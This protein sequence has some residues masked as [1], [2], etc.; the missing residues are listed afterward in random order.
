MQAIIAIDVG[1]TGTKAALIDRGGRILASGYA[2]YDTRT[3][4][5]SVMEQDPRDWWAATCA[6][7][8]QMWSAAPPAE[9]AAVALS[10]QM[11]DLILLDEQEAL[12]PAILYADSRATA[13]A[14]QLVDLFGYAKLTRITGNEQGPSS[15]LAK[16]LWLRHHDSTRLDQARA[17]LLGAHDYVEWRLCGSRAA[18]FTTASTTGLLDLRAN[19]WAESLIEELGLDAGKLP[20]LLPAGAPLGTVTP[21]AAQ[22]TGIPAGTPVHKGCGDLGATT[23]G[24]GA[25]LPGRAYGYLGTSGWIAASLDQAT[26]KPAQGVF[27]LRHPDPARYIQVA[28]ML[29]AGGNLDWLRGALADSDPLAYDELNRLAGQAP[30]GSR[31]L[32]YL[33]YLAGERSPFSDP[34][35]RAAFIGVSGQTTRAEMARAV[36]EGVAMGYRALGD[37]LGLV[38][39]GPL[40]LTGG[41]GKSAVWAQILADVLDRPVQVLVDPGNAPAR[42]A[43]L[44]AGQALGWYKGYL[45]AGDFFPVAAT[46]RP[47]PDHRAVYDELYALFAS[48]YPRLKDA[49]SG[50]ADV[51]ANTQR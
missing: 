28:P 4:D 10:G 18:D 35:A 22:A 3:A 50:L 14:A 1:T 49:F 39:G 21:A 48:L 5:G 6:A 17:L 31:G 44:I 11:Q 36:L 51:A 33:P 26:P 43:A 7:L 37:G 46:Y 30:P 47:E 25:G 45:P 24:A 13:E 38:A 41:G 32:I 19:R 8:A 27:T 42:G 2:G 15:V 23:V 40:L 9:P 34:N 20:P 16:W 29:T 12:G